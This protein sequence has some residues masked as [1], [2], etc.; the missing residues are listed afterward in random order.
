[1]KNTIN[2]ERAKLKISQEMLA[3]Q[4]KLSRQMIHS[5]EAEK[6][7]PSV[8]IALKIAAFFNTTVETLFQLEP[9]DHKRKKAKPAQ[10]GAIKKKRTNGR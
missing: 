1:M 7:I 9:S 8:L 4:V 2:V 5:I 6:K 3:T 10:N